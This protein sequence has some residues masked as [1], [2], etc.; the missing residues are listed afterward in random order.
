MLP[1]IL[2]CAILLVTVVAVF[3]A[4]GVAI[5]AIL[6]M[7]GLEQWAQSVHPFFS[8]YHILT[9]IAIG[10][11][12]LLALAI[13]FLKNKPIFSHYPQTGWLALLLLMYS[14]VSVLWSPVPDLGFAVWGKLWPYLITIILLSPLLITSP[15]N[16][17]AGLTALLPLGTL[18][19]LLLLLHSNWT[20][21]G[22]ELVLEGGRTVMGNPLAIAQMAGYVMLSV[23]LLNFHGSSRVWQYGRWLVAA[24]CMA[25]AVKAGARGQFFSML[26]VGLAFLP[27]SRHTAKPGQF[28]VLFTGMIVLA[29]IGYWTLDF[30]MPT[31]VTA[32]R[33]DSNKLGHDL[34]GRLDNAILL[35]DHWSRSPWTILFGLGNSASYDPRII[36]I[37]PHIVPLEVLGE[38]GV[39]GFVLFI[40]LIAMTFRSLIRTRLLIL[41]N[42]QERGTL[43]ALGAMFVFELLL[44][45]KQGSMAGSIFL[46]AFAIMIG[47]Y[48]ELIRRGAHEEST[49]VALSPLRKEVSL[50]YEKTKAK[51]TNMHNG[52]VKL[53]S[54][55]GRKSIL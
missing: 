12:L 18:L 22:V 16:L 25:L 36:G 35:L 1:I 43:A 28:F 32:T 46:F 10:G 7:L 29:G 30:V 44:S 52:G 55:S 49:A 6:C 24:I 34:S 19:V 48:Q 15:G 41:D 8:T 14:L 17:R 27:F 13:L 20:Y 23:V 47:K 37:Y 39:I 51:H 3:R 45:L 54:Q 40:A 11:I 31:D 26:I 2:Y 42:T 21:R 33:W 9:N 4:P 5:A 53:N 50:I 38:E